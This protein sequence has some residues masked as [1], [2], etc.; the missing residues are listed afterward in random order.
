MA[1]GRIVKTGGPELALEVERNGYAD[2]LAEAR[3][4]ALAGKQ[5][6]CA[7]RADRGAGAAP[8]GW[9]GA[10]RAEA[11]ARLTAMGLPTKRDEYWRYTDPGDLNATPDAPHVPPPLT[12]ATRPRSSTAIDRLKIVFV[13]GVFDA[14]ASDD[15]ALAGVEIERLSRGGAG[16]TS[17]GRATLWRASRR[18]GRTRLRGR[19]GGART[20]F[21]TEGVLIRATGKAAKPSR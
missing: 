11:L 1:D 6:R 4:M 10:A 12:T 3:V 14:A 20:A 7:C 17:T 2:I 5:G 21:A 9:L 16:P 19:F 18:A 8:G 15:C 13:D